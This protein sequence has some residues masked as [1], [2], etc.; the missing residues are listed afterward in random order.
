MPDGNSLKTKQLFIRLLN[1]LDSPYT[2]EDF[3]SNQVK[4]I[5]EALNNK[6]PLSDVSVIMNPMLS[7][8]QI[9]IFRTHIASSQNIQNSEFFR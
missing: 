3:D 6:M 1:A 5:L 8:E 7:S 9:K 2:Y 4:E